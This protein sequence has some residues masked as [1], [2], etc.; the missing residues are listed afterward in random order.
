MCSYLCRLPN[1]AW[2]AG[3]KVVLVSSGAIGVGCYKMGL[4]KRPSSIAQKQALS[5]IGQVHLMRYYQEFLG[6]LGLVRGCVSSLA[7]PGHCQS[8]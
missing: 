2:S 1:K 4:D 6:A 5:A 8:I 3:Y 7:R